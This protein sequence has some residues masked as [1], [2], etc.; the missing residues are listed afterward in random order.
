M[1]DKLLKSLL[2]KAIG[3]KV[4]EVSEEY[5]VNEDGIEQ[6]NKRKVTTK[7]IPPDLTA[8]KAYLELTNGTNDYENM[9]DEELI[10]IKNEL[11]KDLKNES[12][13]NKK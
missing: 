13:K 2:K 3:Y 4:S 5:N 8:L 10:K 11:I 12:C 9:S 1:E 6:L 7:Y